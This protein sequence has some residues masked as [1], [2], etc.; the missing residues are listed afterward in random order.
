MPG[1]YL[2]PGRLPGTGSVVQ[3]SRGEQGGGQTERKPQPVGAGG[4]EP[5][6]PR[7]GHSVSPS[8][9]KAVAELDLAT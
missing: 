6:P 3:P 7:D 9:A 8:L 4:P 2:S 1:F 5:R